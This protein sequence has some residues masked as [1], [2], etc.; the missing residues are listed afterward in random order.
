MQFE[1]GKDGF[2]QPYLWIPFPCDEAPTVQVFPSAP[3]Q[4][5]DNPALTW[6]LKLS[7]STRTR[8]RPLKEVKV[9]EPKS[10]GYQVNYEI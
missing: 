9:H 4:E 1:K 7:F 10:T 5:L 8:N 2:H 3:Q 6:Q